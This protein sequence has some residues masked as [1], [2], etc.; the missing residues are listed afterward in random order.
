MLASILNSPKT[1]AKW[2]LRITVV[3]VVLAAA[4]YF[5]QIRPTLNRAHQV[6]SLADMNTIAALLREYRDQHGEYPADLREAL[7]DRYSSRILADGFN[8]P[9][10]FESRDGGFI[11]VSFGKDGKPDGTNYWLL[12]DSS[13]PME[14]VAGDFSADQVLSDHGW[15][16]EAGK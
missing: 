3:L 13:A 12:R 8:T 2:L 1:L 9:F 5:L 15:H 14:S 6:R 7:P 11:L 16:R 10:H 4:L